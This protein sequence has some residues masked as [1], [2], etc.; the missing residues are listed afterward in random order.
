[1][2]KEVQYV[3]FLAEFFLFSLQWWRIRGCTSGMANGGSLL[4]F[5][6]PWMASVCLSQ[7]CQEPLIHGPSPCC[8]SLSSPSSRAH[9]IRS[10]PFLPQRLAWHLRLR[11]SNWKSQN[12]LQ[13]LHK[14][15]ALQLPQRLPLP[16]LGAVHRPP[17]LAPPVHQRGAGLHVPRVCCLP[18]EPLDGRDHC[19]FILRVFVEVTF[20]SA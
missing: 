10:V 7:C 3:D 12:D 20:L 2:L 14:P 17:P 6:H 19:E 16:L 1:M 13:Q 9:R 11:W 18:P 4:H 5:F 15:G 8:L